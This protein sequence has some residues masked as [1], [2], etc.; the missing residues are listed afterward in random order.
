MPKALCLVGTV[1]AVLLLLVF[2]LDLAI[3]FPFHRDSMTMDVGIVV[4]SVLLGYVSWT[5]LREQK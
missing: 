2:G 3:S 1:V 5:A 4:C